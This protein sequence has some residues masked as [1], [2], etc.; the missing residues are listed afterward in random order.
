MKDILKIAAAIIFGAVVLVVVA[1]IFSG[2]NLEMTRFFGTRMESI[3]TDIYR[4][5]KSYIEGTV[6]DLRELRIQYDAAGEG[7]RDALRSLIFHRAGE[8]SWERLPLDVR[9]FLSNLEQR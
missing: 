5:N 7:H 3:R 9:E 4:E 2:A 1:V 8:L 6:R